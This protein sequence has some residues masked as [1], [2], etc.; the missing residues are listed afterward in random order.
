MH[1]GV[2]HRRRRE[3]DHLLPQWTALGHRYL[4]GP[5]RI[6]KHEARCPSSSGAA[7]WEVDTATVKGHSVNAAKEHPILFSGEMVRAIL[8]GRKTQTRRVVK[9]QPKGDYWRAHMVGASVQW[10]ADL[11]PPSTWPANPIW[12]PYGDVGD[13]LWVREAMFSDALGFAMY[14]ADGVGVKSPTY[15]GRYDPILSRA[16]WPWRG[17]RR[18]TSPAIF[19]PRDYSRITLELTAV[20]VERLQDIRTRDIIAEG[21]SEDPSYLGSANRYRHPYV[22]LWDDING[23]GAWDSNPFVWVLTFKRALHHVPEGVQR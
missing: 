15:D 17:T 2:K 14:A 9:V 13:R 10:T 23:K 20:R 5:W 3:S 1:D 22:A 11:D 18:K 7:G 21:V 4:L 12:C 6:A 19:M 8:E 16:D